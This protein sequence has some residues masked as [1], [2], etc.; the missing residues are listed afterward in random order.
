[1]VAYI[2]A[3]AVSLLLLAVD[4]Y[5]KYYVMVHF[6]LGEMHPFIPR[7]INLTFIYNDGAA[8][9]MLGGRTWVLLGITAMA[10]LACVAILI[11][12]ARSSR[13]LFW[14]ISLVISGGIGNMIDRVFRAGR[15]VDFI[16]LDFMP[17]FPVFNIADCA[18]VVGAG[19]LILYFILD[20]AKET[21]IKKQ[22]R[23]SSEQ[24]ET[25]K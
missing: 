23:E 10:M 6:T 16:H 2:S 22:S 19:L 13:L 9:G 7:L 14:A 4:Q 24:I 1:M 20:T 25:N 5:T 21:Q 8:W 12:Y 3:V 17:T 11:K 18:V 15:V